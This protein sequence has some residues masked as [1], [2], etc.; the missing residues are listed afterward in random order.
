MRLQ[1]QACSE[2]AAIRL[3][4]KEPACY[5]MTFI[6]QSWFPAMRVCVSGCPKSLRGGPFAKLAQLGASEGFSGLLHSSNCTC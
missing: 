2:A 5:I 1:Q 6:S 4:P 3:V